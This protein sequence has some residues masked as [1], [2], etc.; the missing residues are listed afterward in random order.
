MKHIPFYFSMAI[1][2]LIAA[3]FIAV[4]IHAAPVDWTRQDV[5]S[6]DPG[7][8]SAQYTML[9]LAPPTSSINDQQA[10]PD[11]KP[12]KSRINSNSGP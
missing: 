7:S 1:A 11:V 12:L 6:N 5:I 2:G 8:T 9:P 10:S 3:L 4:G